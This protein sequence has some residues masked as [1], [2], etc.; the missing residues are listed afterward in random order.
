MITLV[1]TFCLANSSVT[2]CMDDIRIPLQGVVTNC[3][4][5]AQQYA[6][7][8]VGDGYYLDHWRCE[9]PKA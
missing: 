5:I 4:I 1:L 6:A 8:S 7:M 3:A 9:E 2:A